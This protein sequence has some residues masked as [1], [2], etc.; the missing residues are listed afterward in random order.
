M[1]RARLLLSLVALGVLLAGLLPGTLGAQDT[2]PGSD[3]ARR[4]VRVDYGGAQGS[5]DSLAGRLDVWE[6]DRAA[7][8]LVA[9]V[10]PQEETALRAEGY[11]LE[12]L[13]VLEEGIEAPLDPRYYYYDNFYSNSYDRYVVD[14]LQAVN[15]AYPDIVE[16]IDI[17]DAWMAGQ[18]GEHHR[19]LW[20]LRI[21]NEDIAY[22]EILEKP[23]FVLHAEVHAREVATPE[24]AIRYIKYLTSGYDGQGGYGVDPDVTWL[25]DWHVA[26][27]EVMANPDGHWAN[28]Q[29][30]N[31]YRRKN[32]D[33]DDG[34]T[35]PDSWG[36]DLDRN[37]SFLWGCCGGSSGSPCDETY[38]GPLK[39]SEPET[40]A[41]QDYVMQ[42]VPD[43]NGP[44]GDDEVPPAAPPDTKGFLISLHSYAD[45]ILWPWG[46]TTS[47][48]PN[49][50]GLEAIARKM[51]QIDGYFSP[52]GAMYTVDGA[53]R[54]WS[55]GKLGIPSYVFEVGPDYGSCA[56][57]F[58][59]FG[60]V[61]GIDG[62]PRDFWAENRPVF[63]YAHKITRSPYTAV[64]GP[65]TLWVN[66][67]PV[68]VPQ[69]QP[70]V[71]TAGLQDQR[72]G[73]DPT[74]PIGGA[75]YFLDEPG[76]DGG[77][78]AMAPSDGSWGG[79]YE[80]A[81]ATVD[82]SSLTPG[83]HYLLVH[84]KTVNDEWGPLTAVFLDVEPCDPVQILEVM[85]ETAG[86][87]VTFTASLS[88]T[89]PFSYLWDFGDY[90]SSGE[91]TATVNLGSTGTY[92]FSLTVT[93]GCGEDSVNG[94][95]SVVG[96][97]PVREA[98]FTWAPPD[99]LGDQV[100]TFTASATS[101]L[102]IAFTWSLGDGTAGSGQV[103]THSYAAGDYLVTMTATN[104]CTY[105]VVGHTVAVCGPAGVT[106]LAWEPLTPTVGQLVT[107]TASA[108]GSLPIT[109]TWD[110]GDGS[111]VVIGPSSVVT[112][113]YTT[114]GNHTVMLAAENRCGTAVATDTITVV[115][116]CL[117]VSTADFVYSPLAPFVHSSVLFTASAD[118]TEPLTYT[119]DLGDGSTGTGITCTHAY[120]AA[121]PHTVTL[122]VANCGG[123][124]TA[125]AVHV[126]DVW[127]YMVYLPLVSR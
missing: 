88:G 98:D 109:Y 60:C 74:D 54:D 22:G 71:L 96:C 43:Q 45:E 61:D 69:G 72:Y 40:S 52:T 91:P 49:D 83:R 5:L 75:E 24:L 38:R 111:P 87:V 51:C 35:Y 116:G 89:A 41:F 73:G 23:A 84:G 28:E 105:T 66:V 29:D 56:G 17:G 46:W 53:T 7:G 20:V 50:A 47:P 117:P 100:I 25:V 9:L 114:A 108:T 31:A 107:F 55:Y 1:H 27:V 122:T 106:L 104:A 78:T 118:G 33:W 32:M 65:D 16:L 42:V 10:T 57:F 18:P 127:A 6:V 93:N 95:V 44:N 113:A 77:G 13:R 120:T 85:T 115:A 21:T 121:G 62:M 80:Q 26:Y 97:D 37:H 94:T 14:F 59:P 86:V 11:G 58:P 2:L 102:P 30:I 19:D 99:P 112:H 63:L 12:V 64:Y 81:T 76:A 8:T 36:V 119:W 39:A 125:S 70:A 15:S 123:Q 4:V 79:A 92:P 103:I 67:D 90:G 110:Y 82:T 3:T 126:V 34:C 101:V 48:A 124:G 68:T